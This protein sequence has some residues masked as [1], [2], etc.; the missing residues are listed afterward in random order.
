MSKSKSEKRSQPQ[1][2]EARALRAVGERYIESTMER[3]PQRGQQHG[4]PRIRR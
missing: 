1:G 4:A 3:F 2:P